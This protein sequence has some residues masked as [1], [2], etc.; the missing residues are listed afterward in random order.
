MVTIPYISLPDQFARLLASDVSSLSSFEF[1][2]KILCSPEIYFLIKSL[3]QDIDPDGEILKIHQIL[4]WN[5]IR[6]RLAA[7]YLEH[8]LTGRFPQ[9]ANTAL[10]ADILIIENKLR[11]F[12]DVTIS[13]AF[14]LAFFARMS[15]IHIRIAD[16][17][18]DFTPL[19]ISDRII[20]YMK[21]SKSKSKR[22]D[23]LILNLFLFENYLGQSTFTTLLQSGSTFQSIFVLLSADE[24]KQMVHNL[25]TYAS[26]IGDEDFLITNLN[27]DH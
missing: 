17:D 2:K 27:S 15:L 14:L 13:R 26:S 21:W 1:E 5:S 7:A 18:D 11:H 12:S 8:Y 19:L 4:G 23:W 6:N 22:I 25:I 16:S 24:Q 3:C 20:D 10:V 9:I